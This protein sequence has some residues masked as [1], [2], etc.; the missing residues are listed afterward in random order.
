MVIALREAPIDRTRAHFFSL[1]SSRI[2]SAIEQG[3]LAEGE[4]QTRE[5][6]PEAEHQLGED[7]AVVLAL[8]N[9]LSSV[10]ELQ[11]KWTEAIEVNR[12]VTQR[13]VRV[14]GPEHP[15]TLFSRNLGAVLSM[16]VGEDERG[17]AELA[18][19]L[20][21]RR[22]SQCAEPPSTWISTLSQSSALLTLGQAEPAEALLREV[23][24]K[25]EAR[26]GARFNYTLTAISSLAEALEM[27]GQLDRAAELYRRGIDAALLADGVLPTQ[28]IQL[29]NNLGMLLLDSGRA[30]AA[31][32]EFEALAPR[33]EA[34]MGAQHPFE[35]MFIGNLAQCLATLDQRREAREQFARSI[36]L[37]VASL[38]A[39]HP[40]TKRV[41][42]QLEAISEQHSP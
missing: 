20:Q 30:D 11:G 29:Q 39:E 10:L 27:Q 16:R 17:R 12:E 22:R 38:G 33:A 25:V 35:G 32:R 15:Q 28:A 2:R 36:E 3:R 5:L 31:L 21:A 40:R 41:Q 23:L 24:P 37:L 13:R 14:F 42:V 18:E 9:N 1:Q 34:A 4:A 19:I 6:L 7:D 8:I 26:F